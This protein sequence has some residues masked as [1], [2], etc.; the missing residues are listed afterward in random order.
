MCAGP[1]CRSLPAPSFRVR[2]RLY[3]AA[4]GGPEGARGKFLAAGGGEGANEVKARR[5]DG[6]FANSQP[7][8][9][10]LVDVYPHNRSSPCE[11][12]RDTFTRKCVYVDA[13]VVL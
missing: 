2:C 10:P 6:C 1:P 12:R 5:E 4:F 11:T 7:A 9:Q 8:E 13:L 3:A